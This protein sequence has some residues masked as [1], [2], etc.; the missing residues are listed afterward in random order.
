[1][2]SDSNKIIRL[3]VILFGITAATGLVLGAVQSLTKGPIEQQRVKQKNDALAATLPGAAEFSPIAL[4]SDA[5]II[6]EIYEGRNGSG[7]V[8][9][10]FTLAPRG[11]GGTIV[12]VCGINSEGRVMDIKI[13]Q[14]SET[15]GLGARASEPAFTGQFHER[16]ADGEL[17]VTKNPPEGNSQIHAI[18]GATRT[19]MAV[20]GAVN[21]ARAYWSAH[22]KGRAE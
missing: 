11:Y 9:Y 17:T 15:P 8:G 12:L 14:S 3:G 6:T 7:A 21:A 19:S 13:L 16:L 10:N 5:G 22:F 2:R 1:M 4:E 20:T 18:S